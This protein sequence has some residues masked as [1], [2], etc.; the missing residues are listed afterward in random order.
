MLLHRF[1]W[2]IRGINDP[3]VDQRTGQQVKDQSLLRELVLSWAGEFDVDVD[4]GLQ[5]G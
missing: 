4:A 2:H 1:P 5:F 3:A